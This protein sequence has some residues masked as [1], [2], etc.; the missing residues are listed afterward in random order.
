MSNFSSAL[1][2]QFLLLGIDIGQNFGT[3]AVMKRHLIWEIERWT[4]WQSCRP[5]YRPS[6]WQ[7]PCDWLCAPS[8]V[9]SPALAI[10]HPHTL[11]RYSGYICTYLLPRYSGYICTYIYSPD[12]MDTSVHIYS[13]SNIWAALTLNKYQGTLVWYFFFRTCEHVYC[14]H[15]VDFVL[16]ILSVCVYLCNISTPHPWIS[17]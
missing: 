11:P 9:A 13:S 8:W 7:P 1:I 14:V 15:A 12:T 4:C 6:P 3:F 2:N 5:W 10:C 16:K 17:H